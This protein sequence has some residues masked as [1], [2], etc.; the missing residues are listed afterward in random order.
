M[1]QMSFFSDPMP[2]ASPKVVNFSN[3]YKKDYSFNFD[4]T[5][6][7]IKDIQKSTAKDFIK[8]IEIGKLLNK[9]RI[10]KPNLQQSNITK[11]GIFDS[12]LSFW[13]YIS[14]YTKISIHDSFEYIRAYEITSL[15]TSQN[16]PLLPSVISHIR[17]LE[18]YSDNQIIELWEYLN[19][20]YSKVTV[21]CIKESFN[22]IR[23]NNQLELIT[24]INTHASYFEYLSEMYKR[25]YFDLKIKNQENTSNKEFND[26]KI[27]YSILEIELNSFENLIKGKDSEIRILKSKVWLLET[28]LNILKEKG[29]SFGSNSKNDSNS[30]Y[31]QS[32]GLKSDSTQ[33]DI[34]SAYRKLSK[35]YH[36][37]SNRNESPERQKAFENNFKLI[38]DAYNKLFKS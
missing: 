5:I 10:N 1:Q 38:N 36:P 28:E 32:L 24:T 8:I 34:K 29:Y 13:E 26:L 3:D 15:L 31:F 23:K 17:E 2:P 4:E 27:K 6:K 30:I 25:Q 12:Y 22:H 14:K 20:N 21:A 33:S 37:D 16:F 9:T 7:K 18:S 19:L 11:E 35:I